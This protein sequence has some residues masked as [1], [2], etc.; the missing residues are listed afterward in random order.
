M[1]HL[2]IDPGVH[3]GI[4]IWDDL[5]YEF[6]EI[7]TLGSFAGCIYVSEFLKKNP[8]TI[9]YIEDANKRRWY[10]HNSNEKIQGAGW[11][12]TLSNEW[13]RF[14]KELSIETKIVA[15]KNIKTIVNSKQFSKLTGWEGKTSIHARDAAAM[16]WGIRKKPTIK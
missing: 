3:T 5:N 9:V 15:P 10:G 13:I 14:L 11:I 1:Y 2:A 8:D 12:K 7:K 16:V 6:I 4:A